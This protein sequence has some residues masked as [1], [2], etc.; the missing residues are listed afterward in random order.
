MSLMA[1]PVETKARELPAKVLFAAFAAEAGYRVLLGRQT[2]VYERLLTTRKALIVEHSISASNDQAYAALIRNKHR[3]VSWDEEGWLTFGGD[4]YMARRV[5]KRALALVDRYFAWGPTQAGWLTEHLPQLADRVV[6]TGN[7]R[8]DLLRPELRGYFAE[9]AARY[10]AQHGDYL[11]FNS[12]FSR[13][14]IHHGDVE[15]FIR[16][17]VQGAGLSSEWEAFYRGSLDFSRSL[18]EAF[19]LAVPRVAQAFPTRRLIVR[20]H[21][22]ENIDRWRDATRDCPNVRVVFEGTANG[23]SAGAAA[24][25]HNGCTT[26]LEAA[27][28][29]RPVVA[30]CPLRHDAFE[31]KLPNEV[32]SQAET[33][34]ELIGVLEAIVRDGPDARRPDAASNPMVRKH[35]SGFTGE[36]ASAEI[37]RQIDRV[38]IAPETPWARRVRDVRYARRVMRY[39]AATAV[40]HVARPSAAPGA[41]ARQKFSGL[42]P[43]EVQDHLRVLTDLLG[44]FGSVR[45]RPD[46]RNCVLIAAY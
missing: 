41:Y 46:R 26:G 43:A 28:M 23:W 17:I 13:V 2:D 42:G 25:L 16:S 21:P 38:A 5:S 1:I 27:L 8:A 20:P 39:A 31:V 10:R 40:R 9:E 14:N 33:L 7:P 45:V 24:V 15:R 34:D 44:R 18:F 36:F 3:L 30:Y 19:L 22:S 37:V 11:L 4:W 12:N 29:E 6:A 32:S 35:L